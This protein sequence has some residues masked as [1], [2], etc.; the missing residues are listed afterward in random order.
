MRAGVLP[1]GPPGDGLRVLHSTLRWL[2]LTEVWLDLQLRELPGW[3]ESRVV[4][5]ARENAELFPGPHVAAAADRGRLSLLWSRAL[6]RSGIR[7]HLGVLGRLERSYR[8]H[9][10]HSH[11]GDVAWRDHRL[12]RGR[13]VP[14]VVSFYGSDLTVLPR[15]AEWRR[16]Y[17]ELFASAA[18][19]LCEGPYMAG[20]LTSLGCPAERV[21]VHRLG[22]EVG[23]IPFHPRRRPEGRPLRVLMAASFREKKGLPDAVEALGLLAASGQAVQATLIGGGRDPEGVREEG[24]IRAA[25]ERHGLGER[26][27]LLGYVPHARLAEE[28]ERHDVFLSP[29][30]TAGNGD[31]EGGA[32]VAVIEMA[33]AG[34][35][36]ISTRHCDIPFVLGEPNRGLLVAERDPPALARAMADLL[37]TDWDAL[38]AANRRLVEREMD[39]RVQAERLA[40]IYAEV[41]GVAGRAAPPRRDW[42]TGEVSKA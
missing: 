21:R 31:G 6:R 10:I 9:L 29:S 26:I 20:T 28:A 42:P 11:F 23:R 32:P 8:P 27:R 14:Q 13:G 3:V 33:A 40:G 5:D 17:R 35:P 30:V 4:C 37:T 7:R 1:G 24:R 2:P 19:V 38:T 25:V 15:R 16:R 22:V 39:S 34:L 36:V 18:L 12:A 41:A